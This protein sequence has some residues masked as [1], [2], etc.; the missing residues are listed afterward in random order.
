MKL[1]MN[2]KI[3]FGRK[4]HVD[5]HIKLTYMEIDHQVRLRLLKYGQIMIE[6]MLQL[7]NIKH[8]H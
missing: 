6:L 5:K 1:M 3:Y 8:F 7:L 2:L 4:F